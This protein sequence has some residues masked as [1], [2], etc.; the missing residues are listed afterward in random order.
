VC[1]KCGATIAQVSGKSG[2]YY[3]CLGAT[4]AACENRTLVRRT[5]AE[6]VIIGAVLERIS[7]PAHIR[8]VLER[9]AAEVG[10]LSEHLPETIRIKEAELGS[11]ERRLGNFVDFIG[12]GR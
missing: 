7:Q 12:E 4:K 9:V 1:G 8:Y 5:L 6:Q 11:E 2:E 3:G 10:K